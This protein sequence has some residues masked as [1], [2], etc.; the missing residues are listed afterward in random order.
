MRGFR[1]RLPA[2]TLLIMAIQMPACS[3]RKTGSAAD[4][5]IV[6]EMRPAKP[7]KWYESGVTPK[8]P[9]GEFEHW[10]GRASGLPTEDRAVKDAF[11][12]AAD[13]VLAYISATGIFDYEKA[14]VSQGLVLSSDEIG[15]I[16]REATVILAK[17]LLQKIKQ[18][19]V[20]IIRYAMKNSPNKILY[21]AYVHVTLPVKKLDEIMA[22]VLRRQLDEARERNNK[23][24]EDFLR[25]V[26][27]RHNI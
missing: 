15:Q 20:Q 23:A 5:R 16:R 11:A 9:K 7:F 22:D 2:L 17:S 8:D 18:A 12:D 4:P 6:L 24:A 10:I 26:L 3:P 19:E 25:E 13:Y 21:D 1:W 27:K 14:N